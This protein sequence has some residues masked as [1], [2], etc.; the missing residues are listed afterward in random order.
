M[1]RGSRSLGWAIPQAKRSRIS[2]SSLDD[3]VKDVETDDSV[4]RTYEHGQEKKSLTDN[5]NTNNSD[6]GQFGHSFSRH[7]VGLPHGPSL[8]RVHYHKT[9][10]IAFIPRTIATHRRLLVHGGKHS[11][12]TQATVDLVVCAC[13]N[14]QQFW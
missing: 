9:R 10:S 5:T 13:I 12:E 3:I 4:K 8:Q 1:F 14:S 11:N 7:Q 6:T 2:S